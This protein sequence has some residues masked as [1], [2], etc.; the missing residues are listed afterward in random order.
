MTPKERDSTAGTETTAET[1]GEQD[2]D[3]MAAKRPRF[4]TRYLTADADVFQHNAWYGQSAA[5]SDRILY[6]LLQSCL[7][8]HHRPHLII[9][10]TVVFTMI[11]VVFE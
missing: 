8:I 4:G 9:Y 3:G 10:L 5:K 11:M 1:Q 6:Y 2:D 7:V